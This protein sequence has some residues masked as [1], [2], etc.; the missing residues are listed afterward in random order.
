M[1]KKLK[2]TIKYLVDIKSVSEMTPK[3]ITKDVILLLFMASCVNC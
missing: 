3:K 1:D 2:A